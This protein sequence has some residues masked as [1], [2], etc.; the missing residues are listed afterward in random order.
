[1]LKQA[2]QKGFSL[3][4]LM[5]VIAIIGILAA[6]AIPQYQNYIARSQVSE[7]ISMAQP[8]RTALEEYAAANGTV[9]TGSLTALG[10]VSG[11]LGGVTAGK[12]V[13]SWAVAV[14][15]GVVQLTA[16]FGSTANTNIATKVLEIDITP[17]AGSTGGTF[18][19]NTTG[20]TT[21]A[22]TYIPSSC[23]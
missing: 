11:L 8:A 5:I 6:I 7:A 21:I 10:G 16:T 19:C 13:S 22:S 4:E 3:I 2:A 17:T 9:T 23:Q 18:V 15:S 14:T 12:Y 20:L 1:M